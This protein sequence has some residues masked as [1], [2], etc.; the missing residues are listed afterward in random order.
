MANLPDLRR[1]LTREPPVSTRDLC[2]RLGGVDRATLLRWVRRLEG[3]VVRLGQARRSA[4]ALRRALGGRLA[5]LPLY[6]I[7][8]AGSGHLLGRLSLIEPEGSALEW[9]ESCP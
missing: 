9:L 7:D 2:R 4:Y 3:E 8:A 6:R 1:A 5:S